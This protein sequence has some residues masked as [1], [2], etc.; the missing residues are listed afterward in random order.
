MFRARPQILLGLVEDPQGRGALA[1]SLGQ[2]GQG[3]PI[4]EVAGVLGPGR[5]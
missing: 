2:P 1:L 4:S 3:E 5:G